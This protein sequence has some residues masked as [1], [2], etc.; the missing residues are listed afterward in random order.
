MAVRP[1]GHPSSRIVALSTAAIVMVLVA[2]PACTAQGSA[3]DTSPM[4]IK[5]IL[6]NIRRFH[7]TLV[8]IEGTAVNSYGI[9]RFGVVKLTDNT[10]SLFVLTTK[11]APPRGQWLRLHGRVCQIAVADDEQLVVLFERG[12]ATNNEEKGEACTLPIP[13]PSFRAL[14][15]MVANAF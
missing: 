1:P 3:P 13:L 10:A 6:E 7:G 9:G 4:P 14:V 11:T 15:A 2:A 12:G 5:H 8:M